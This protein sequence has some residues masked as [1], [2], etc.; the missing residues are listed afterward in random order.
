MSRK[1]IE[2][3][4]NQQKLP[5]PLPEPVNIKTIEFRGIQKPLWTEN[6]AKLIERYLL[7]FVYIT[8]HGTYI[9]GFAGPQEIDKHEMWAAKLVLENEP[10]WMRHFHL[11]D[12]DKNKCEMLRELKASQPTHDSQNRKISRNIEIYQGDFN[13]LVK[14]LLDSKSI[15]QKEA[16]FCLLDQRTFE[17]QWKTVERLAHYKDP[18]FNKIELFYFLPNA[19]QP[20]A[21]AGLTKNINFA[22]EWWGGSDLETL[23]AMKPQERLE[24]MLAKFKDDL[25]YKYVTPW[26][27]YEKPVGR[28]AVMYYMIHATD[29]DEAPKLME[30]AYHN[31]V[32]PKETVHQLQLI[33]DV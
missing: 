31:V 27:I 32:K 7:Y 26:P 13:N 29:H 9:D 6:K 2:P 18:G 4:P 20:R 17:C 19:W 10:R 1:K 5:M 24:Q 23:K 11:Y 28:G 21:L 22:T 12:L 8:K 3:C 33:F 15:S 16:T 25:N 14:N 30:R